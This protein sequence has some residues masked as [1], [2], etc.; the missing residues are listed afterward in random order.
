MWCRLELRPLHRPRP[1][2]TATTASPRGRRQYTSTL[3]PPPTPCSQ[4]MTPCQSPPTSART[5]EHSRRLLASGQCREPKPTPRAS[6]PP[7]RPPRR[8]ASTLQP[9]RFRGGGKGG[10]SPGRRGFYPAAD[11][12][13]RR[14]EIWR[15]HDVRFPNAAVRPHP[16]RDGLRRH[17]EQRLR[18]EPTPSRQGP[19]APAPR[20]RP[21][22]IARTCLR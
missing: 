5:S 17:A 3:G 8:L 7:Q 11:D 2:T 14:R 20:N 19:H 6:T 9:S 18:G 16:H 13:H 10:G 1:L 22:C 12:R 15:R 21:S 4:T